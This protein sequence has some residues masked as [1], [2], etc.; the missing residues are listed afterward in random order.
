MPEPDANVGPPDDYFTRARYIRPSDAEWVTY[1]NGIL[2]EHGAV[3]GR[4]I[5]E[6]RHKARWQA[7]RLIR[8]MVE[9]RIHERWQLREHVDRKDGGWRWTVEYLGGPNARGSSPGSPAHR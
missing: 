1:C 8:L 6:N 9:L 5:Y 4:T 3:T 7:R 2:M